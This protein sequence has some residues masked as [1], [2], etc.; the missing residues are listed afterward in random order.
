[1]V[2]NGTDL[3]RLVAKIAYEWYCLRNKVTEVHEEFKG[4]IDYITIG[5]TDDSDKRVTIMNNL[6]TLRSCLENDFAI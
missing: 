4:I 2:V 1:M 6:E 5:P 3:G